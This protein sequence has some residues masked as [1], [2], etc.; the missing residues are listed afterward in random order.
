[1]NKMGS[2]KISSVS[3]NTAVKIFIG[4][5]EATGFIPGTGFGV[6]AGSL[7]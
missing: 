4:R 3:L 7:K 1:M 2:G 5:A 6:I